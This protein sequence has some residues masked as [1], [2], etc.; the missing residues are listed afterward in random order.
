MAIRFLERDCI[1]IAVFNCMLSLKLFISQVHR[2]VTTAVVQES[3][4]VSISGVES[5][6]DLTGS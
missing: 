6:I 3:I 4:N 2:S 1:Q 5:E